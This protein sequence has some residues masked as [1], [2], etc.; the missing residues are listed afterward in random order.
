MVGGVFYIIGGVVVA[1]LLGSLS[2]LSGSGLGLGDGFG[3]SSDLD[4]GSLSGISNDLVVF[5]IIVGAIM[6]FGGYLINSESSTRRRVG[7]I[8]VVIM[9]IVGGLTSLG[10]LLIGFIL[11]SIG[12]YQ[13]L[14]YRSTAHLSFRAGPASVYI[15]SQPPPVSPSASPP[16]TVGPATSGPLNYCIKC[17]SPLRPGSVFCGACGYRVTD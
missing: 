7:V 3:G 12:A 15:G 6:I 5:S 11:A 4:T 1:A 14:T 2:S 16:V 17:G 10:G 8:L 13:A 9:I